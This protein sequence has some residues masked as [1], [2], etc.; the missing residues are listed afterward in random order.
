MEIQLAADA[1]SITH[2]HLVIAC[3]GHASFRSLLSL[4]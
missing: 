2:K 4:S 1:V 3:K